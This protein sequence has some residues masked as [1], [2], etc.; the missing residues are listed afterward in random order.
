MRLRVSAACC[1]FAA[2]SCTLVL[3]SLALSRSAMPSP[4][5]R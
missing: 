5:R 4:L 1:M 2:I 3:A